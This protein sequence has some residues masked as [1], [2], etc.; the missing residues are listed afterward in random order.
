MAGYSSGDPSKRLPG[1]MVLEGSQ[2]SIWVWN[3]HCCVDELMAYAGS[4]I[5]NLTQLGA[6]VFLA[7]LGVSI[8]RA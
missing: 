3:H 6:I 1:E 4:M 7:W 5:S 2:Q 8:I